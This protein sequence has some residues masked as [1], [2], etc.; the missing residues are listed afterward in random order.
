MLGSFLQ[1]THKDRGETQHK[2]LKKKKRKSSAIQHQKSI[3]NHSSQVGD[4]KGHQ[5]QAAVGF[6]T[7]TCP[8]MGRLPSLALITHSTGSAAV[9]QVQ[10]LAPSALVLQ[11][12]ATQGPAL[13][14]KRKKVCAIGKNPESMIQLGCT[15]YLLQICTLENIKQLYFGRT[16]RK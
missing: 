7:P 5:L 9:L 13:G 10:D 11:V 14:Q 4:P 16:C 2:F 1:V 3:M 6:L 8:L 15:L 12:P